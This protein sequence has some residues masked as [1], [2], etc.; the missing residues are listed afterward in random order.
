MSILSEMVAEWSWC[1]KRKNTVDT[2][3]RLVFFLMKKEV[4]IGVVIIELID[5]QS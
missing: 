5:F 2:S 3:V 4:L 1:V